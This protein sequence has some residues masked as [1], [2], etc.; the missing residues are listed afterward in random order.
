MGHG[1][2]ST[3]SGKNVVVHN[4][5]AEN[6][7]NST[8]NKF[9]IAMSKKEDVDHIIANNIFYKNKSGGMTFNGLLDRQEFIDYNLFF[10]PQTPIVADKYWEND[11]RFYDLPPYRKATGFGK[12]SI[13]KDPL[14]L[15][16]ANGDFHL[17]LES[18]A[19]DAATP[20][21]SS[22]TDKDGS[23]RPAGS[24]PDIGAYEH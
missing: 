1:F 9:G 11:T 4:V 7:Y 23:A 8:K 10:Q 19:I 18:P 16:P 21:H 13:I 17:H 3:H 2:V 15:D 12:H 5:F 14:I 22:T 6:G 20:L 24:G